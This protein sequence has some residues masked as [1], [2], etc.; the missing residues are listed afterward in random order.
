MQGKATRRSYQNGIRMLRAYVT[1]QREVFDLVCH[2]PPL[3]TVANG[4]Q[5]VNFGFEVGAA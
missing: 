5:A 1:R 2:R 3:R 4:D